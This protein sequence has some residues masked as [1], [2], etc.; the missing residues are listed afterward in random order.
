[1]LG[2][3]GRIDAVEKVAEVAT[4]V[5]RLTQPHHPS[6]GNPSTRRF[7][8]IRDWFSWFLIQSQVIRHHS[9][10]LRTSNF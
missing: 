2:M 1:M 7:H 10:R 4:Y 5:A 8:K 3:S 9:L 6:A